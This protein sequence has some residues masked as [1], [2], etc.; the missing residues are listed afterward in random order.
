[1][2]GVYLSKLKKTLKRTKAESKG[3]QLNVIGRIISG[4]QAGMF[5]KVLFSIWTSFF[6]KFQCG[7][8]QKGAYIKR[9]NRWVMSVTIFFPREGNHLETTSMLICF[10]SFVARVAP[11]KPI[12]RT[13]FLKS[14]SP[15]FRPVLKKFRRTICEKARRIMKPKNVTMRVC[16]ILAVA[17]STRSHRFIIFLPSINSPEKRLLHLR[18]FWRRSVH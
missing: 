5:K 14:E 15:Q 3:H 16:S 11:M 10:P 9:E 2:K 13:R 17:S 6:N 12:H 18:L 7:I 8:G 1:M 4:I